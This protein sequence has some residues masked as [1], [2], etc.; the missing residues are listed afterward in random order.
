MNQ[1]AKAC[2]LLCIHRNQ[3][4]NY[5]V[6][7]KVS[8]IYSFLVLFGFNAFA[9]NQVSAENAGLAQTVQRPQ[10]VVE[11]VNDT[12]SQATN[13]NTTVT[14]PVVLQNQPTNNV[15]V[16]KQAP[17][18]VVESPLSESRAEALR[19]QRVE[20]EQQTESMIV[21]K[22][23]SER[24]KV[25]QDRARKLVEGLNTQKQDQ[26][27]AIEQLSP[28]AVIAPTTT[29]VS[30]VSSSTGNVQDSQV[31]QQ[32]VQVSGAAGPLVIQQNQNNVEAAKVKD[33]DVNINEVNPTVVV[34]EEDHSVIVVKDELKK[35]DDAILFKD[36][37]FIGADLGVT[38]YNLDNVSSAGSFGITGGMIFDRRFVLEGTYLYSRFDVESVNV[39]GYY[40]Y[41]TGMYYPVITELRQHNFMS[42][43]KYKM[44][45]ESRFSPYVGGLV[46]FTY[47]D[48]DL[49]QDPYGYGN[50][51]TLNSSSWAMDAGLVAGAD[52]RLSLNFSLNMDIRYIFNLTYDINTDGFESSSMG[53]QFGEKIEEAGYWQVLVG[54]K[55]TF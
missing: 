53:N 1:K 24:M 26:N 2:N 4:F 22:L 37:F 41:Y 7:M 28:T 18:V 35:I 40:D 11:V 10:N 38:S 36:R 51:Q 49:K 52:L 5:E 27:R 14:Q 42:T 20:M 33:V 3:T 15:F 34:K 55:F 16:Q 30:P 12:P 29:V 43:F 6:R 25:E 54:S 19:K 50:Y 48:Y 23:E 39:Y 21:E 31:Q 44:F 13:V 17:T 47:R 32:A 9:Q 45:T 8:L 46:S